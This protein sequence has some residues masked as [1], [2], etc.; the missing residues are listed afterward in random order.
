MAMIHVLS[1]LHI[2][3]GRPQGRVPVGLRLKPRESTIP[4]SLIPRRAIPIRRAE[5]EEDPFSSSADDDDDTVCGI[6][7]V[8]LEPITGAECRRIRE[9]ENLLKSHAAA[10]TAAA[11]ATKEAPAAAETNT[12][13]RKKQTSSSKDNDGYDFFGRSRIPLHRNNN[14]R[15]DNDAS[16]SSSSLSSSSSDEASQPAMLPLRTPYRAS[17]ESAV[18]DSRNY[19]N[20][21]TMLGGI[22]PSYRA[23]PLYE[24]FQ[25]Q[26]DTSTAAK[27]LFLD[28][29]GEFRA[30]LGAALL[31]HMLSRLRT[32]LDVTIECASLGAIDGRKLPSRDLH[33]TAA[34]MGI[35]LNP[36]AASR[37][38]KEVADAV[39]Y[40]LILV[41]DRFDYQEVIRDVSMLDAINPGG[42][43]SGRVR[44]LGPFGMAARRST[45]V[46]VVQDIADPLYDMYTDSAAEQAALQNTA[47][48]LAFA[49]RGLATYLLDLQARC[50]DLVTLR[51]AVSV[52]LRCPLLA[53]EL[54]S[55]RDRNFNSSSGQSRIAQDDFFT[56]RAVNGQRRVVRRPSKPRG[57]WKDPEN[58][59]NEL[60]M[61]IK[62]HNLDRLP[63]QKELRAAGES[64][65]ATA[66]DKLGGLAGFSQKIGVP[67]ASRRPNGYW[68]DFDKLGRALEAY[69]KPVEREYHTT[70]ED[71]THSV[72][73]EV[74]GQ[75]EE[76]RKNKQIHEPRESETELFWMPSAQELTAAGRGDLLRAIREHGGISAVGKKLGVKV[77][78]GAGWDEGKLLQ[79]L[80][81]FAA[82]STSKAQT[83]VLNA[84]NASIETA[85][86]EMSMPTKEQL[87]AAGRGD[88]VA[89]VNKL[90]GFHYF[91]NLYQS[92]RS[93]RRHSSSSCQDTISNSITS[94]ERKSFSISAFSLTTSTSSSV[95]F[96]KEAADSPSSTKALGLI[97][98]RK[99]PLIEE[100]ADQ[101]D[102]WMSNSSFSPKH[103]IPTRTELVSAGRSDLWAVVQ[104]CGGGR[105]V[106][107]HMG[108]E[109][110][111]TRGRR[112]RAARDEED[113]HEKNCDGS[114]G[115]V[116]ADDPRSEIYM[117][118]A[119]EEF[120]FI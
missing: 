73:A 82:T 78:R 30:A 25:R 87:I 28:E 11:A 42:N 84:I 62:S 76:E 5:E 27:I 15:R 102:I 7:F 114:P 110:I 99:L 2:K 97:H 32:S 14:Y 106:A 70:S 68:T 41:M 83:P 8:T 96:E 48:E 22:R 57:Y 89:A 50:G 100:V 93:I 92:T 109:W 3:M 4:R 104:R 1:T 16:S 21:P 24:E 43:Y 47:R 59:E 10:A 116:A 45:P 95:F 36:A 58:I 112:K 111:E 72:D 9:E 64:S 80:R 18:E 91:R 26:R 86:I 54:P 66:I 34:A 52:S 63:T 74:V 53:G 35:S 101:L 6:D 113:V 40:D 55:Q 44:V 56:V 17:H 79:E 38:F 31:R 75:K 88:L 61:W 85:Q 81:N 118:D 67:M 71:F 33:R 60:K 29:G 107:E 37:Q 103:R 98:K 105:R 90:G 117:L 69:M 108:L 23:S 20:P 65:L 115:S 19:S 12:P 39:R 51:E 119:Y 77:R 94:K 49:C 13:T 46:Q 120:V